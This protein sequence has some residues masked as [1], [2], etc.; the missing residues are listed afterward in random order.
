MTEDRFLRENPEK[1]YDVIKIDTAKDMFEDAKNLPMCAEKVL[2]K[3]I[4]YAYIQK[5]KVNFK[6]VIPL[7]SEN[8]FKEMIRKDLEI[9]MT[10]L[11]KEELVFNSSIKKHLESAKLEL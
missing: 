10:L 1:Q 7:D 4:C 6:V 3:L 8:T 5:E 11:E 2:R 9:L